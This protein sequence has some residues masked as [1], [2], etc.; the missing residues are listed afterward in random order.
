MEIERVY[1]A[2][3]AIMVYSLNITGV[4]VAWLYP[5]SRIL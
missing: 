1:C 3:A 5:D 4:E 2:F